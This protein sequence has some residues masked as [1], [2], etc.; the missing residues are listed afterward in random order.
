MQEAE[1]YIIETNKA[2]QA[3]QLRAILK[4]LKVKFEVTHQNSPYNSAMIAK[5]KKSKSQYQQG[6]FTRVNKKGLTSFLE[7][8]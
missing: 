5:V 3:R 4:A 7:Q 8:L 2:E 6:K 1:I